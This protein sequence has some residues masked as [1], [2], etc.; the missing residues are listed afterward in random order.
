[1]RLLMLLF[2]FSVT[3]QAADVT[4]DEVD[5]KTAFTKADLRRHRAAYRDIKEDR[6]YVPP[7]APTEAE[8][9]FEYVEA[10]GALSDTELILERLTAFVDRAPDLCASLRS[11]WRDRLNEREYTQLIEE[12][13]DLHATL[14]VR[15]DTLAIELQARQV[16]E[17]PEGLSPQRRLNLLRS[18]A[19]TKRELVNLQL[20]TN[21][22]I[23][24]H[25][26][27]VYELRTKLLPNGGG[28]TQDDKPEPLDINVIP[29]LSP[30]GTSESKKL[31][32]SIL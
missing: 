27:R 7:P 21:S 30:K 9:R 4:K 1:M 31:S 12:L 6:D 23:R 19:W 3:A 25:V 2:V 11:A 24:E 29:A 8:L 14:A 18:Y 28:Y 22:E 26:Q 13:A 16:A 5:A 10:D 17:P 20:D 32:R 15:R